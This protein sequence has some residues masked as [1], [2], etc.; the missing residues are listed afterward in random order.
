[1]LTRQH[2]AGQRVVDDDGEAK[3]LRGTLALV[4]DPTRDQVVLLLGESK[5]RPPVLGGDTERLSD[6]PGREVRLAYLLRPEKVE[7]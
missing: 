1:V 4:L 7:R 2:A 5:L 3:T 6:L